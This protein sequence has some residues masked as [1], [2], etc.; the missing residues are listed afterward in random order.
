MTCCVPAL[1]TA[2]TLAASASNIRCTVAYGRFGAHF[3]ATPNRFVTLA[4]RASAR[5]WDY[6]TLTVADATGT[7]EPLAMA[8]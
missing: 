4:L 7:E 6:G 5:A 3:A 8:S 2:A 1:P